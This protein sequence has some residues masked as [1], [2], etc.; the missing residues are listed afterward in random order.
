MIQIKLT[1][2]KTLI[3]FE[4]LN[5]E[6]RKLFQVLYKYDCEWN[7]VTEQQIFSNYAAYL[8]LGTSEEFLKCA[9]VHNSSSFGWSLDRF[10]HTVST[11]IC[12]W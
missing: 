2:D 8:S 4:N 5:T 11:Q 3:G 1:W 9:L 12:P 10:R 7:C 6:L